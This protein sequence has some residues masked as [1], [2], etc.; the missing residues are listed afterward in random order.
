MCWH[1]QDC[2][3]VLYNGDGNTTQNAVYSSFSYGTAVLPCQLQI[4]SAGGGHLYIVD[5]SNNILFTRP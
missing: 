3:L 2:N 5:S 1:A 4:S